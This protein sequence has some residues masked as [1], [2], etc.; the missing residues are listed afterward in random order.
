MHEPDFMILTSSLCWQAWQM[1]PYVEAVLRQPRSH[2]IIR[3]AAKLLQ[4]RHERTRTRTLQRSL[5]HLQQLTEAPSQPE[6]PTMTRFRCF[7]SALNSGVDVNMLC[8]GTRASAAVN[9]APVEAV[10]TSDA[11]YYCLTASG[12]MLLRLLYIL[13]QCLSQLLGGVR[14]SCW[15]FPTAAAPMVC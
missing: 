3:G 5:M 1:A 13:M 14:I 12:V 8:F 4:A 10:V 2:F 6:P 15:R 9:M 11:I 7:S